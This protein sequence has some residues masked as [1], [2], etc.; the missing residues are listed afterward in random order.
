[1][2]K[3]LNVAGEQWNPWWPLLHGK[4]LSFSFESV[5]AG[6]LKQQ[7]KHEQ[8]T[9]NLQRSGTSLLITVAV[10]NRYIYETCQRF[11]DT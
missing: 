3:A 9:D 7:H 1:M 11:E 2:S 5:C 10:D 4:N 6:I 8:F